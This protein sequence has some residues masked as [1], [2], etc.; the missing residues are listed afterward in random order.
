MEYQPLTKDILLPV[1][2]FGTSKPRNALSETYYNDRERRISEIRQAVE[3]GL[4]HIDTASK[5]GDGRVEDLVGE[6]I[7]VF[8]RSKIFITTKLRGDRCKYQT[9]FTELE[10]S[11]QRLR[12]TYIDLYLIHSP[13]LTV[14]IRETM[15]AIDELVA[16]G[17][18]RHIG[19]SN[20]SVAQLVEAQNSTKNKIV[21][22]Q[23]EYNLIVRNHG[24]RTSNMESEIIPYCRQN[25]ILVIAYRPLAGGVFPLLGDDFLGHLAD[26]YQKTPSQL[27]LNW[28]VG[29][30]G[31][32]TLIKSRQ[33]EHLDEDLLS[34]G[35][36]LEPSD[37]EYMDGLFYLH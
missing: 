26:K 11:L 7:R 27:A 23:I 19:V 21:A 12:T 5:Y 18:I 34:L 30:P 37:R 32:V 15:R 6:A 16:S 36:Q 28:L 8:D 1:F 4:T 20:F 31:I 10:A 35:W 29:K 3:K 17:K 2:G 14:P 33:T 22:N 13:S 25:G 9:V 24:V